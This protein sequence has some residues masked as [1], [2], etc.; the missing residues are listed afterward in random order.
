MGKKIQFQVLILSVAL[1]AAVTGA[2]AFAQS[3]GEA[4]YKT[5]CLNCHGANGMA[6]TAVGKAI[7]VKPANDPAVKKLTEA[8]M[9]EAVRNGMGRMQSYKDKMSEADIKSSVD[10]FRTFVK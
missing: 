7:K 2:M 1:A 9:I 3:S 5:K 8:Q 10:Y 4:T 6:E